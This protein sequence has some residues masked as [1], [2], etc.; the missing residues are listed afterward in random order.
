MTD[1]ID[2]AKIIS[3]GGATFILVLVVI[4]VGWLYIQE[5][6]R[7]ER[8]HGTIL[9]NS[10]EMLSAI[11]GVQTAIVSFKEVLNIVLTMVPHQSDESTKHSRR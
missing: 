10:K 2:A 3:S 5:R 9:E 7:N 1:F 6:K 4:A 11:V 8:L